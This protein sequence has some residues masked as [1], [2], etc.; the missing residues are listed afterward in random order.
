[1]TRVGAFAACYQLAEAQE[2]NL[3]DQFLVLFEIAPDGSV[4]SATIEGGAGHTRL[5]GCVLRQILQLHFEP[6]D[7]P[8]KAAFPFHFKT[9]AVLLQRQ[10]WRS[11]G[12]G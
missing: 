1:M 8:T 3:S 7:L 9:E 10:D 11:L 12:F 5:E 6:A 4:S 2:P